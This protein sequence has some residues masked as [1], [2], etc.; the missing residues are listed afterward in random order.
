MKKRE[1]DELAKC[2]F[3]P[4]VIKL[5]NKKPVVIYEKKE[6][7]YNYLAENE[8]RKNSLC[9]TLFSG[10]IRHTNVVIPNFGKPEC[11]EQKHTKEYIQKQAELRERK[12]KFKK[13]Q[14]IKAGS[15]NL[16]D[17]KISRV[18]VPVRTILFSE[19][20]LTLREVKNCIKSVKKP[21]APHKFQIGY[22]AKSHRK[23][24]FRISK[25][26]N[27]SSDA[28]DNMIM[29]LNAQNHN[30]LIKI[31]DGISYEEAV[32]TLQQELKK[33]NF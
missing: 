23:N 8:K 32:T 13:I 5:P 17:K 25:N 10:R 4:Q 33:I 6:K 16:F 3:H 24:P 21:V 12:E 30:D 14:E 2:T 20:A 28:A 27:L 29:N 11:L 15:G 7:H 22:E 18:T 26:L 31:P 1:E 9:E 19:N